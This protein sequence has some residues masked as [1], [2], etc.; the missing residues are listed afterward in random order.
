MA[1]KKILIVDDDVELGEEMAEILESE[2]YSAEAV[3]DGHQVSRLV[4]GKTYDLFLLD[5]KMKEL[6]GV[7]VL[8]TILR[9][10]PGAAA[11]FVS[12]KPGLVA[13]LKEEGLLGAVR[14]VI[15]K[16]FDPALLL[17]KVKSC[18]APAA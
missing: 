8:K 11:L 18:L 14:G 12:G 6:S 9:T 4:R 17:A 10:R 1:K 15:G 7:D 13:L 16:P 5:Y 2:G 3:S